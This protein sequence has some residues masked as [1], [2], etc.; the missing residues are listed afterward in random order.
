MPKHLR[1][2][3]I[4]R[5]PRRPRLGPA[6]ANDLPPVSALVPTEDS[7]EVTPHEIDVVVATVG[8]IRRQI[9]VLD[10]IAHTG[11]P[12]A[13]LQAQD[14]QA[15][16]SGLL[17]PPPPRYAAPVDTSAF[18]AGRRL[19]EVIVGARQGLAG[20][21]PFHRPSRLVQSWWSWSG[22]AMTGLAALAM[23]NSM[24]WLALFLLASRIFISALHG[25]PANL[26]YEGP[27]QNG[28]AS[29]V[30]YRCLAGHLTDTVALVGVTFVLI[31]H[32]HTGLAMLSVI[33][34]VSMLL[35]SLLRVATLQVGVQQARLSLERV[36]RGGSMLVALGI[37]AMVPE[38]VQFL[39]IAAGG[40]LMYAIIETARSRGS[41]RAANEAFGDVVP[42]L[43]ISMA[44]DGE[45]W[46][47]LPNHIERTP[48]VPLL[49][50][51]S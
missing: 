49:R 35:A 30:V 22:L 43:R 19:E 51:A 29:S 25:G 2:L 33:A 17:T 1:S 14:A 6:A 47:L 4:D 38:G 8:Q 18:R 21:Y 27:T 12:T 32:N 46:Q 42:K 48:E 5:G 15:R 11:T 16:L 28:T 37:T 10:K 9:V 3:N 39:A 41:L 40:A 36:I 23:A 44:I 20:L 13:R 24:W 31:S 45:A 7:I 34:T 26:P 50:V